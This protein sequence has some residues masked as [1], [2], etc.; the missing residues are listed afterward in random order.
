L[1]INNQG[2][3]MSFLTE[4]KKISESAFKANDSEINCVY[5]YISTKLRDAAS[6]GQFGVT[7]DERQIDRIII[8]VTSTDS[9]VIVRTSAVVDAFKSAVNKFKSDGIS[10]SIDVTADGVYPKKI[11]KISFNW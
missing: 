5:S 6:K 8:D 9:D 3:F 7:L 11:K 2:E 10:A 4:L 1:E